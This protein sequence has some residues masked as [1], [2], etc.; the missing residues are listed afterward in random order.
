MSISRMMMTKSAPN[1]NAG[2]VKH[3]RVEAADNGG[4]SVHTLHHP[5]NERDYPMENH[6]SAHSTKEEA[7]HAAAQHIGAES[8]LEEA[9]DSPAEEKAESSKER[10]KETAHGGAHYSGGHGK[11]MRTTVKARKGTPVYMA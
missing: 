4:A 2:K 11:K 9:G 10:A 8:E 6:M 3:V 1:P 7:M 5:A